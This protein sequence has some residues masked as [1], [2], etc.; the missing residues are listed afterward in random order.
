M[1]WELLACVWVLGCLGARAAQPM[2]HAQYR[3]WERAAAI[4]EAYQQPII[5]FVSIEDDKATAPIRKATIAHPAFQELCQPNAV[6]YAFEVPARKIKRRNAY[7]AKQEKNAPPKADLIKVETADYPI[8]KSLDKAA[9]KD[10]PILALLTSQ[11][12]VIGVCKP[13]PANPSFKQFAE[14]IQAYFEIGHYSFS[15]TPKLQK[16]LQ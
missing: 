3:S 13:D 8:L 6:L 16:A 1:K 5:A 10:Y 9:H 15:L 4:A 12:V 2:K 14:D 7:L 11:G